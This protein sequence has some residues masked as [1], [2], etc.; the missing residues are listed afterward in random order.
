MYCLLIITRSLVGNY[1]NFGVF[2]LYGDPA[3]KEAMEISFKIALS[4]PPHDIMHYPKLTK[5][6]FAFWEVVS[7][8]H[9]SLMANLAP[10]QFTQILVSLKEGLESPDT[11][12]ST[13]CCVAIDRILTYRFNAMPIKEK[14]LTNISK[15]DFHVSNNMQHFNLILTSLLRKVLFED[16]QNLWSVSRPLFSIIVFAPSLFSGLKS[17]LINLQNPEMQPVLVKAFDDL[18]AEV[19]LQMDLSAKDKFSQ[20]LNAFVLEVKKFVKES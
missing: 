18:F 14:D 17:Q 20:N 2:G 4:I 7:M 12:A 5:A 10:E 1:V 8:N 3:F 19:T 9:I 15:V 16:C 13:Q 6:Y 11:S